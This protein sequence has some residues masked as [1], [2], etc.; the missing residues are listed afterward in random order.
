MIY[1]YKAEFT[2]VA[3]KFFIF[4][5]MTLSITSYVYLFA[6]LKAGMLRMCFASA[7]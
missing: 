4:V 1:V 5:L 2:D 3:L 6:V 7:V